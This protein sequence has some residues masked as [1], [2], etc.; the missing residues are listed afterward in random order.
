MTNRDTNS[1]EITENIRKPN[2]LNGTN[3][4]IFSTTLAITMA[5]LTLSEH[6]HSLSSSSNDDYNS[7]Q[8]LQNL[9]T[10]SQISTETNV[11][12]SELELLKRYT[13][14]S[15]SEW[16]KSTYHG[17]SIGQIIGLEA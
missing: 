3:A 14:I 12:P 17:K 7:E 10:D 16:F 1:T 9:D 4:L 11:A 5:T 2:Y 8:I 13:N 15:E 6:E